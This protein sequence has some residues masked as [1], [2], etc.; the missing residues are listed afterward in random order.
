MSKVQEG[1]FAPIAG[2]QEYLD[3]KLC[4]REAREIER[5]RLHTEKPKPRKIDR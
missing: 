3:E 1:V 2:I 5:L 4:R